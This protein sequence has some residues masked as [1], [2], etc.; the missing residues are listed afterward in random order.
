MKLKLSIASLLLLSSMAFAL[1]DEQALEDG[2]TPLE[3]M[4]ANAMSS[5][6]LADIMNYD[7]SEYVST[8]PSQEDIENV[9]KMHKQVIVINKGIR[10]SKN[11]L[12]QTLRVFKDGKVMP[13]TYKTTIS[14]EIITK[15]AIDISTGREREENATESG[16]VYFS[17]TPI[18]FY[19][20]QRLYQNYFSITWKADMPNA[21]FFCKNFAREC[22]IAIHA[23]STSKYRALGKRDSGGC[24]RTRLDISEQL[25][26]LVMETG[27][28][29]A[30]ENYVV[31]VEATH[32]R[33]KKILKNTV[34]VEQVN[35]QNGRLA[36]KKFVKSWDT[37]IVVYNN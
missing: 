5:Q 21:I 10:T 9:I 13:L 12:G 37:V 11:P 34:E 18:G 27:A 23:T 20:P 14:H 16:R 8:I 7:R 1:T 32:P 26:K 30:P 2:M 22:G 6:D 19:R 35:L 33:R 15:E 28:G 25:R 3:E 24:I 17:T 4:K 31:K 36:A 29:T